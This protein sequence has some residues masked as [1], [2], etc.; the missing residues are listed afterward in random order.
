MIRIRFRV[1]FRV[2]VNVRF[3]VL[4]RVRFGVWLGLRVVLELESGFGLAFWEWLW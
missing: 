4:V 1:G 2:G 3:S